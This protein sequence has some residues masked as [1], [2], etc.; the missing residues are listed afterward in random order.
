MT[1][2]T[3]ARLATLR[4]RRHASAGLMAAAQQLAAITDPA[5]ARLDRPNASPFHRT[6]PVRLADG[7]VALADVRVTYRHPR[8][9]R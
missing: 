1:S 3:N 7:T 8:G 6:I 2:L 4:R 9:L 5:D